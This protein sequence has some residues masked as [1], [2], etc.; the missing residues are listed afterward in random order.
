MCNVHAIVQT[1]NQYVAGLNDTNL[2]WFNSSRGLFHNLVLCLMDINLLK[3]SSNHALIKVTCQYI[4]I[5][6]GPHMPTMDI[7]YAL[8]RHIGD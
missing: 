1:I 7:N 2:L 4:S 8:I 3:M 5:V 6:Y